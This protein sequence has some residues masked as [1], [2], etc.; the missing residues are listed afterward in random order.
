MDFSTSVNALKVYSQCLKANGENLANAGTI[1]GRFKEILTTG[2]IS[3]NNTTVAPHNQIFTLD[4]KSIRYIDQVGAPLASPNPLHFSIIGRGMAAVKDV[5]GKLGYCRNCTFGMDKEKKLVNSLG[6]YLQAY[7]TDESG[8]LLP[9]VN[10]KN[11]ATLETIDLKD[12][13]IPPKAS[14]K[15]DVVAEL[16]VDSA[17]GDKM[18]W[19]MTVIDATGHANT[20]DMHFTRT[21]IPDGIEGATYAWNVSIADPNGLTTSINDAYKQVGTGE[22]IT[23]GTMKVV[24]DSNGAVLGYYDTAA[25]GSELSKTP[26]NLV[27]EWANGSTQSDIMMNFGEIGSVQNLNVSAI[28]RSK[29]AKISANGYQEGEFAE[30]VITQDGYGII[31]YTNNQSLT[32]CRIPLVTFP[33]ANSLEEATP[34]VFRQNLY[35]GAAEYF[36]PGEGGT[37]LLKTAHKE[38]STIDSTDVYLKMIDDQANYVSNIKA[39]EVKKDTFNRLIQST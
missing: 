3:I 22:D 13:Y 24:F 7:R 8:K 30:F 18:A 29:N 38:G 31:N 9:S 14:T 27:M 34:G 39:I 19:A 5:S 28:D 17:G 6:Q 20:L 33:D 25:G 1:A 10:P 32:Y 4:Q 23:Y 35:S 12:Q 37:G 26:P 36:F 16:P 21:T 15:L 2:S 11:P